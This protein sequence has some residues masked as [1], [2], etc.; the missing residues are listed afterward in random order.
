MVN[1]YVF[2]EMHWLIV[3]VVLHEEVINT[4]QEGHLRQGE[5]VHELFHGVAM[6]TLQDTL[7][8]LSSVVCT[9]VLSLLSYIRKKMIITLP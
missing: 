8:T 5:Y 3:D 1:L 6:G 9:S 2:V 4:G 7:A